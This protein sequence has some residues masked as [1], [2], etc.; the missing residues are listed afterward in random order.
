MTDEQLPI[1]NVLN[2]IAPSFLHFRLGPFGLE[3]T[4]IFFLD[5]IVI[6]LGYFSA[7]FIRIDTLLALAINHVTAEQLYGLVGHLTFAGALFHRLKVLYGVLGAASL[8]KD[9]N[10]KQ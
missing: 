1:Y 4:Q 7:I 3:L 10:K 6:G 2:E 5:L 9:R 8:R